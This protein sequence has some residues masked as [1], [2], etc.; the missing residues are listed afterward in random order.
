MVVDLAGRRHKYGPK[1]GAPH[2]IAHVP[3]AKLRVEAE[4]MARVGV[5]HHHIAS[6]LRISTQTLLKHYRAELD[7]GKATAV[8]DVA[9]CLVAQCKRG[10]TRAIMFYLSTQAGWRVNQLV[11]QQTLGADGEPVAPAAKDEVEAIR[12]FLAFMEEG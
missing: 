5:P 2:G 4:A 12:D 3:T 11:Q 10:D 7:Q 8:Y 1:N 6:L 9:Q